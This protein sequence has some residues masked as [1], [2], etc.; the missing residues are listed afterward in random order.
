[1]TVSRFDEV[2]VMA[3]SGQAHHVL[4][5]VPRKTPDRAANK[6]AQNYDSHSLGMGLQVITLARLHLSAWEISLWHTPIITVLVRIACF[7][8]CTYGP[9]PL[10]LA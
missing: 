2:D 10:P 7:L 8:K 4:Q 5:M 1:M 6:I 3:Q 9:T